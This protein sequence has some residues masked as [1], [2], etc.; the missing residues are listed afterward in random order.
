MPDDQ[1]PAETLP[2]KSGDGLSLLEG[3]RVLDLTSSIAGPYAGQLLGDM[4]AEVIKIERPSAGDD[5]RAWGPP[6]L[7]GES[8]W[9]TS[10]NR[11]KR[12]VALDQTRPAGRAVFERLVAQAD[13]VLL[14]VVA[15][16]Q[17]KLGL[18]FVTLSK[19]NPR[20]IHA[21]ITGFG[22]TGPRAETPCYDLIAEGCSG[23]MDMTGEPDSP[24]QKVGTPAADL[25]AG[26][27]AAMGVL[28]AVIRRSRTGQGCAVDV[29]MVETMTRFMAPRLSS[30]LGS[31][32]LLRRSGG[33]DSVIAIYQAFDTADRP[34]TLGL[35][36][37]AI[38]K[39]FWQTVGEPAFADQ[40]EYDTNAKR[41]AARPALV[42]KIQTV[43]ITR[44][45]NE[46]LERFRVA[47]VPAGPIN[48]LD[49]VAA[50]LALRGAGLLYAFERDGVR[51]PQVGLGMRFD[52]ESEA[53]L[54]PPPRLG[55]H[56]GAVL[57]EW[58]GMPAADVQELR[59][60]RILQGRA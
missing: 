27:D 41:H 13:I 4:G 60:D 2:V 54:T 20:L 33:R 24:P 15:S 35:G 50:D 1:T 53:C 57:A 37:N 38:W 21:S 8:L 59:R 52:G 58:L 44:S 40:P 18:D 9:F 30:Y 49:E 23:V 46:W 34:L 7:A 25:L 3:L 16:V 28:A 10:V 19:L 26:Q 43:L 56:T 14:N 39:R 45:R 6:F 29:S 36:N 42:N 47:R 11:N 5:A 32:E 51:T 17:R 22:L 55:E 12:S 31:G 48:R